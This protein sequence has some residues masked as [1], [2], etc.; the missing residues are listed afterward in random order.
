MVFTRFIKNPAPPAFRATAPVL[1]KISTGV[2]G[3]ATI[4]P[5]PPSAASN[6]NAETGTLIDEPELT[7]GAAEAP[8]IPR[9]APDAS[10]AIKAELLFKLLL[11]M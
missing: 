5:P 1:A 4:A 9:N 6:E 7:L 3:G 2:N 8:L 11:S 10:N